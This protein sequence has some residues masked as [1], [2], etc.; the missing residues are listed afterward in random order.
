MNDISIASKAQITRLRKLQ[1]KKYRDEYRLYIAEGER[2]IEQLAQN[3]PEMISEVYVDQ[4][5]APRLNQKKV[6]SKKGFD[7]FRLSTD[8]FSELTDTDNPQ[9]IFAVCTMPEE[10][11]MED[12]LT[13]QK[14]YLL[15]L[16]RI[17]DPGNMGTIIRTAAWFG[18]EGLLLAKGN[19][20]IFHP[21]VVRSTAGATGIIP[22]V[23]GDLET[24]FEQFEKAD[25]QIG[26]LALDHTARPLPEVEPKGKFVMTIGNEANGID[27][28]LI[29]ENRLKIFI[30]GEEEINRVES[31]NAAVASGIA[32]YEL[33][34]KLSPV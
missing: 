27:P 34:Q 16:D 23:S 33:F 18:V 3:C 28:G 26:L 19:V 29:K 15:A 2:T 30:P 8:L 7:I 25:W 4:L 13:K 24:I 11:K 32:L 17:Q 6:L 5:Y 22:Y 21:K 1:K 14:G 10:A 12:L 31:L 9:G 20:D